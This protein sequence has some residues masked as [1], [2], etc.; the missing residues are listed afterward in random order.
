[1]SSKKQRRRDRENRRLLKKIR[2]LEKKVE[3]GKHAHSRSRSR[4]RRDSSSSASTRSSS[5]KSRS[6]SPRRK[7][8]VSISQSSNPRF[9]S[10]SR[11]PSQSSCVSDRST[12]LRRERR[13]R[14][15]SL[16]NQ[17]RI[18]DRPHPSGDPERNL[19][20]ASDHER[21]DDKNNHNLAVTGTKATNDDRGL[22]GTTRS[23]VSKRDHD[24]IPAANNM[25]EPDK[26]DDDFIEL[27]GDD[28]LE[29]TIDGSPIDD[30]IAEK[31]SRIVKLGLPKAIKDKIFKKYPIPKNCMSLKAPLL[32]PEIKSLLGIGKKK[33][34]YQ[35]A[36]QSQL[37]TA[38]GIL[39]KALSDISKLAKSPET[40][41]IFETVSD[42]SRLL[43]DMH[44]GISSTRRLFVMP[45]LD[46]KAK[47]IAQEAPID[48]LL[49]GDNFTEKLKAAKD[50]EKSAKDI[51]KS[52]KD[53]RK[54]VHSSTARK[55]ARYP[56]KAQTGARLN[57][58]GPPKRNY[59][60][61]PS[62]QSSRARAGPRF[63]QKP[64]G[65]KK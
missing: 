1:M 13:S 23:P 28:D 20:G 22:R 3:R 30:V 57:W 24:N 34:A 11:S 53:Y 8:Q 59:Q 16:S 43:A 61:Y 44:H 46:L 21:S 5:S 64:H 6:E 65:T 12:R 9:S 18:D 60:N 56:V 10:R 7:N 19:Q 47:S 54:D 48:V 32:N 26:L 39:G 55:D 51:A 58:N 49:F 37:G 25:K 2:K 50:V 62:Y 45:T 41:G 15:T 52:N 27:L 33:D 40:A 4:Q 17:S 38:I 14:S 36:S 42:A 31:Y 63:P 29:E 35:A